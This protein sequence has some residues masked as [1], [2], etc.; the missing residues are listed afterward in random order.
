M[1]LR[2]AS[3][4]LTCFQ[5]CVCVCVVV[6]DCGM[7]A[8]GVAGH[9]SINRACHTQHVDEMCNTTVSQLVN[10]F[11]LDY[12]RVLDSFTSPLY[13]SF[14]NADALAPSIDMLFKV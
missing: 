1:A 7:R 9:Q 14:R 11:I 5:L 12:C 10:G 6:G 4:S 3:F 2:Y 13:L 8:V